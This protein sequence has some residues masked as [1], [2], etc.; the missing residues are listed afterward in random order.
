VPV[1]ATVEPGKVTGIWGQAS[2]RLPDGSSR[3]LRIGDVVHKGDL[4]ITTQN[5]IV[6]IQND[7]GVIVAADGQMIPETRPVAKVAAEESIDRVI[8]AVEAGDPEAAT[9]AGAANS[10][11]EAESA[12]RV[13]RISEG[14]GAGSLVAS[15]SS[16]GSEQVP[17][18]ATPRLDDTEAETTV[19]TAN[20]APTPRSSRGSRRR[21]TL[22][23]RSP[24]IGW[25]PARVRAVEP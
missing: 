1:I 19:P 21:P 2:L 22:T 4:I 7:Q 15:A 5:G 8:Q 13:G 12:L 23:A 10:G 3:T 17:E 6:E 20:A 9:A 25:L 14:V 16:D 18:F 24:A 11:G